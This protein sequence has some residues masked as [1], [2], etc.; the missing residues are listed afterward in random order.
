MKN[1]NSAIR[2]CNGEYIKIL[3]ADDGFSYPEAL[4]DYID[5]IENSELDICFGKMRGVTPSGNYVYNLLSCESNYEL[6]KSSSSKQILNRLY[7]RNF[8]PA[9]AWIARKKLFEEHGLIPEDTRLIEDYPYWIYLAQNDV[10]FGYLDKVTIDYKM[11]GETSSGVYGEA[12]M[13]DMI[14][15]YEKYIFPYDKRFGIFQP[16]YNLL[17]RGG[18][19]F[20]IARARWNKLSFA[21][22]LWASIKYFP[23]YFLTKF[24]TFRN[25]LSNRKKE[26]V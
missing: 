9:P 18:L 5:F 11:S 24:Q 26:S 10:L 6:L 12:F 23:F 20:Y 2:C 14:V 16:F 1:I 4:S 7:K 8:L 3:S 21:Q 25:N 15:I 22:K 17:K 19:N 13:N